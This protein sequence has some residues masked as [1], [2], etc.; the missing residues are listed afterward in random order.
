MVLWYMCKSNFIYTPEESTTLH[1]LIFMKFTLPNIITCR[2]L[3]QFSLKSD[4]KCG[5]HRNSFLPLSKVWPFLFAGFHATGQSL[6]TSSV[7]IFIHIEEKFCKIWRNFNL[8]PPGKYSFHCTNF[9]KTH[10]STSLHG[11]T[12]PNSIKNWS[13]NL[14]TIDRY[15]CHWANFHET[16]IFQTIFLKE[17]LYKISWKSNKVL[18]LI[19]G[20]RQTGGQIYLCQTFS[21]Y[22]VKNT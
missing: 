9:H 6:W 5:K 13:R 11:P 22:F 7:P 14:V 15:D 18:L 4:N 20:H 8:S 10:C 16:N 17:L 12:K 21:S 19:L 1:A 2:S 3:Q